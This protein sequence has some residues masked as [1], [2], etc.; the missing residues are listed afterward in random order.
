MPVISICLPASFSEFIPVT[1]LINFNITE[2]NRTIE[3]CRAAFTYAHK[4]WFTRNKIKN[5]LKYI[6]F[7][8]VKKNLQLLPEISTF[9]FGLLLF[10]KLSSS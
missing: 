6:R 4:K 8:S 1:Y 9:V 7:L 3:K 2:K 5:G 10:Y